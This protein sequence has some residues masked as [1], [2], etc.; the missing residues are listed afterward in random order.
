MRRMLFS[1]YSQAR[2]CLVSCCLVHLSCSC[3]FAS[4]I[5]S[6]MSLPAF[7][8]KSFYPLALAING[9]CAVLIVARPGGL[10]KSAGLASIGIYML[11]AM[12]GLWQLHASPAMDYPK[13]IFGVSYWFCPLIIVASA[14]PVFAANIW[15]L[16]RCAPTRYRLAGFTA[17]MMAGAI[18]AWTYSWACIEN[19]LPFVALWY[20]SVLFY[21]A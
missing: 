8:V 6:A 21:A 18:G 17:G 16:R 7:W 19:G 20:S 10:P 9:I 14:A 1:A 13:L 3:M 15:F 4:R 2:C 11:L 5:A 12:L